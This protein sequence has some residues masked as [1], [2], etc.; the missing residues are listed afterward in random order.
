[1][2]LAYFFLCSQLKTSA[3]NHALV[4]SLAT[5]S[6]AFDRVAATLA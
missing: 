5:F 6:G 4:S 3:P 1:V 2:C